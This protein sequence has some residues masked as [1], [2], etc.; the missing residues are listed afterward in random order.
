[1]TGSTL[2]R[3]RADAAL[4]PANVTPSVWHL[5]QGGQLAVAPPTTNESPELVQHTMP[6]GYGLQAWRADGAGAN[7]TQAL[8]RMP[9]SNFSYT[10]P[11]FAAATE[12]AGAPSVRLDYY[13]ALSQATV[14]PRLVAQYRLF[15]DTTIRGGVGVISRRGV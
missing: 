7:V 12:L 13:S 15:P 14:D 5:R 6:A 1:L 2:W 3:H 10:T 9:L 11:P 4:P 8:A